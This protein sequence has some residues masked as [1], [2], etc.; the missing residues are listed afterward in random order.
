MNYNGIAKFF[1]AYFYFEKVKRFGDVPWIGKPLD[2]ADTE[3]LYGPRDPRTLIMDSVLA[4][5]NY[6]CTNIK[7]TSDN[8]RSLVT[9]YVA[10]A[11][12]SRICLFEGTFRKYH[13]EL[14]LQS[15]AA[16]WLNEAVTA[17]QAVM[18]AGIYSIYTTGGTAKAYRTL[19]TNTTPITAEVMTPPHE[20]P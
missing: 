20:M 16:F 19:F 11:L 3:I 2:V 4:D 17:A 14:G 7:S 1:R 8:T 6:A 9:K 5:I 10:Y 12:K 13:T 18:D 15:T